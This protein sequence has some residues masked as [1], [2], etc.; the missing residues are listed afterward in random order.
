MSKNVTYSTDLTKSHDDIVIELHK[1]Q[2]GNLWICMMPFPSHS[3]DA[4][5]ELDVKDAKE[6]IKELAYSFDLLVDDP[7]RN[8]M[9][10][11]NG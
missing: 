4:F 2:N 6:I 9:P 5:I 1:N 7:D 3:S 11:W 10:T 8:F